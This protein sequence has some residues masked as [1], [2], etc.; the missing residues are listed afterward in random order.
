MACASH[1]T[2]FV[3]LQVGMNEA[4]SALLPADALTTTAWPGLTPPPVSHKRRVAGSSQSAEM[5]PVRG[6]DEK[7]ACDGQRNACDDRSR[8][9]Q[10]E[11][12]DLSGDEPETCDQDQQEADF[13]QCDARVMCER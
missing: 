5:T 2:W 11:C 1:P 13:G 4:T 8:R 12:R 3:G 7:H 10:L 9:A 6:D